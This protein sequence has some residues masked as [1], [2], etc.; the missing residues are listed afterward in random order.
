MA[1][2]LKAVKSKLNFA[3]SILKMSLIKF[4]LYL[5]V[6]SKNDF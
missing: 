2:E 6:I 5:S 4:L 1:K 3:D